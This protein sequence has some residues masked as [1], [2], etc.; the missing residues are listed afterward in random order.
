[1]SA[2][3]PTLVVAVAIVVAACTARPNNALPPEF[4]TTSSTSLEVVE[5]PPTTVTLPPPDLAEPIEVVGVA[6][7]DTFLGRTADGEAEVRLLGVNAP[8]L[9]ECY[10]DQ[11]RTLL[12]EL[13]VGADEV[14]IG[15]D[16]ASDDTDPFGRLLRYVFAVADG[17]PVFVNERLVA[18]GAA[19]ALQNGHRHAAAFKALEDRAYASG[20]G[21]WG[22]FACSPEEAGAVPD[23]PQLRVSEV[24]AD[25][26]GPDEEALEDEWV[27]L[28]NESYTSV[29]LGGWGIRDES[30]RNRLVLPPGVGLAPGETL[31]I[32]TGCGTNGGRVVYWCSDAPIWNN[33]GD[34][35][36]VTDPDGN[37]VDRRVWRP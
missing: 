35:V 14:T 3:L 15:A 18:E 30:T 11:A 8:E 29:D 33:D 31:R 37:V 28:V 25:P 24:A 9:D 19:I 21:L 6:D 2:R 7:G 17:E 5:P 23:R 4:T 16:D 34:T 36:I 10:G 27:E 13:L 12:T 22:T 20:R 26:P 32:V 1:M